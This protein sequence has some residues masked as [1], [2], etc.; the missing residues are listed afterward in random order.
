MLTV[1]IIILKVLLVILCIILFLAALI[2]LVP[3]RYR[4]EGGFRKGAIKGDGVVSWMHIVT[5]SFLYRKGCAD[6]PDCKMMSI[7]VFGFDR[8]AWKKQRAIEQKEREKKRRKKKLDAIREEDPG[9]YEQLKE[10]ARQKKLQRE[11]EKRRK[12]E[13]A[14]RKKE[15]DRLRREAEQEEL[16]AAKERAERL[17]LRA[18]HSIS[19][20]YRLVRAGAETVAAAAKLIFKVVSV[21]IRIIWNILFMPARVV[22]EIWKIISKIQEICATI[23]KWGGFITD[24][25]TRNAIHELLKRLIILLKHAWPK[26]IS[27]WVEFGFEDSALMGN[28][29]A[30]VSALYPLYC[31]KV[32]VSPDFVEERVEGQLSAEGRIR[33]GTVVWQ[34]LLTILNKDVRDTWKTYKALSAEEADPADQTDTDS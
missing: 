26:K 10:E 2:L 12:E 11:E 29:M 7:R 6:T 23:S 30:V 33:V 8:A 5:L 32:T 21:L 27:G 16:K 18:L 34:L 15:E 4:V 24:P 1:L 28:V 20:L 22:D 14:Q 31:G 17:R 9:R 13:E 19:F 3:L 25:A